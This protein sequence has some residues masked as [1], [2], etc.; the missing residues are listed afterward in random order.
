MNNAM[1]LELADELKN[2]VRLTEEEARD[3][4]E[5]RYMAANQCRGCDGLG[6]KVDYCPLNRYF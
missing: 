2:G 1:T 5:D 3:L 4:E 6:H